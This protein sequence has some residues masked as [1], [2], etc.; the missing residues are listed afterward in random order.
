MGANRVL[1]FAADSA[2][3]T[4]LVRIEAVDNDIDDG[5]VEK[6]ATD[7][8]GVTGTVER[9]R[10]DGAGAGARSRCATT[11]CPKVSIAAPGLATDTGHVFEAEVA[12]VAAAGG[13]WVLTRA[14]L[15]D[16]AL[17]VTVGVS[18]S[19]GDF[20]A[21]ATEAADQT[22][23]FAVDADTASYTPAT[24]DTTDEAHGTV[25]VTL[26]SGADY[27]IEGEAAATANVRDDD[28]AGAGALLEL[29][30][31]PEYLTVAEGG[32]ARVYVT[33]RTVTDGTFT[34]MRDLG[35]VFAGATSA[36]VAAST[37][38]GTAT[39]MTDYAPMAAGATAT[40]RFMDLAAAGSGGSAGFR[41]PDPGVALPPVQTTEDAA[42][43]DNETFEVTLALP[44]GADARIGLDPAK[45]TVE[46]IE[47]PPNGSLRIC[48][49]DGMCVTGAGVSCP[50]SDLV[51]V[52]GPPRS[53]P[54][55][56]R[57]EV[58]W[59][60]K[61]GTICDDYWTNWDADVAC[62]DIGHAAGQQSF[63]RSHFGGAEP[64][65]PIW[66]DDVECLGSDATLA[67]CRRRG[68]TGSAGSHNCSLAHTEDAGV[69]CLAATTASPT[70]AVRPTTLTAAPGDAAGYWVSLTKRPENEDFW[71][72]PRA[73]AGG[74]VT[75]SPDKVWMTNDERGWSFAQWVGV[76]VSAGARVGAS[77]AI[78]HE[79][80]AYAY[81]DGT[82][83]AVPDVTVTVAARSSVGAGPLPAGASAS[84]GTVTVTFDAPLDSAF[85]PSAADY[86]V[87]AGAAERRV[88]SAYVK[89]A[90][91]V[92]E[93]AGGPPANGPV[94]VAYPAAPSSPL[95]DRAG[96]A[97]APFEL[98]AAV[99]ETDGE[100]FA[101]APGTS[102]PGTVAKREGAAGLAAAVAEA[103]RDAPQ[104]SAATLWAPRRGVVDLSELAALPA[105][106]RANL[107][108]NAVTDLGPLAGL[109]RLQRLD[110][111][112]NAATDVWPLS[113]LAGLEVLDLSGNRIVDVAA[114]GGLP[115]L[116]VLE[117]AGNAVADVSPL[118]HLT[119]LR[120]LGLAGN[121]VA[122]AA[123][124]AHLAGLL[125]LDLSGNRVAD[126]SPLGNLSRLVWL[127]LPGNR[128]ERA[129]ALGRLTELRWVWLA[130]NAPLAPDAAAA[131]P[132]GVW[133]DAGADGPAP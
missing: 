119:Q 115:R 98:T 42:D 1:S 57:L 94:R 71:A 46:I 30:V 6:D 27:D 40:V 89:G 12:D 123:P 58:A 111:S 54:A 128:L 125:R 95:T 55:E 105:L 3:G 88:A 53:V 31:T 99:P 96:R 85:A 61:Y 18:E 49:A 77:H 22:V 16:A 106:R 100:P 38:G 51:C 36:T 70:V 45:A 29:G 47:G 114:L 74:A 5:D 126:A 90:D 91:L 4:G 80:T 133:M 92:L 39:A 2:T 52:S 124:L 129:D 110:L 35:R 117:L 41:L 62:R 87:L 20:V 64:G 83:P 84:G 118:L 86:V 66:F 131:L 109:A 44:I 82:A 103:L 97:A 63:G 104:P 113:G 28:G 14:G 127:R 79:T 69:R 33:A 68:G 67:S 130:D 121:R 93:L 112:G 75:V 78:T 21:P 24:A 107:S 60:G 17:A 65:V 120:Y 32:A 101:S 7:G 73:P 25:T 13:P 116:R 48:G 9:R 23:T 19:G 37:G 59:D 26:K 50:A 72:A 81:L 108:D 132:A 10:G 34:E 43:E 11:T 76:A 15:L 102:A 8:F 122:D 56:G